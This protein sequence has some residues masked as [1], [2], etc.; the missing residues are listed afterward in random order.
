MTIKN[1]KLRALL[2]REGLGFLELEKGEG[3]FYIWSP[4]DAAANALVALP[5]TTILNNSF[6][7]QSVEGWVEDI[8]SIWRDAENKRMEGGY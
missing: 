5:T 1:L 2:E 8:K 4:N 3:Y 7:Q 6:G